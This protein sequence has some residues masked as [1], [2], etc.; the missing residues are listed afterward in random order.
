MVM[1]MTEPRYV[2]RRATVEDLPQ[3]LALWRLEQLPAEA[4]EK[5]F[6]EF[7]VV[8]DDAG[9]VLAAVG[10]QIAGAQGWL[11]DESIAKPELSDMLRELLWN[12]LQI[13]IQNHA[14]ERLW[15]QMNGGFWRD[16]GFE[17]AT[18]D[19]LKLRPAAFPNNEREWLVITLRAADASAALEREFAEIKSLQAQEKER[20]QERIRWMKRIALGVTV[21]VLLLVVA[22]AV[23]MLK[24]GPKLFQ[25]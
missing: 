8:S 10:L 11:H 12:R 18:E 14:L 16:R 3:L 6:T 19:Q 24:F 23:V 22:W 1:T 2:A 7:Q 9:L 13:I 20:T 5:R 15:T 25:R 4:L 17:H 21:F